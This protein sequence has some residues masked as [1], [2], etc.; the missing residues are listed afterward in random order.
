[1]SLAHVLPS[2]R[3]KSLQGVVCSGDCP[4]CSWYNCPFIARRPR[5]LHAGLLLQVEAM[6]WGGQLLTLFYCPKCKR[7]I[8]KEATL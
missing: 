8:R 7:Y 5:M 3:H 6:E 1:M 4:A 2:V